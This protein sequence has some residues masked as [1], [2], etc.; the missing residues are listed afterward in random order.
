MHIGIPDH[1]RVRLTLNSRLLHHEIWLPFMRPEELTADRVMVEVDRV[2]HSNDNW[3]FDDVDVN[4]IHAPLPAGAG[5]LRGIGKL[6]SF[7]ERK[8]CIIQIPANDNTCCAR[9]IVTAKARLEEDERW[10]SIRQGRMVQLRLARELLEQA[11]VAEGVACGREEWVKF[12]D[13]LGRDYQI[14]VISRDYFNAVIY[15]GP[16]ASRDGR[17]LYL[18]HARGHFSVITSMP[19]FVE[20]SYYCV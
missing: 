9:A 8:K 2:I 12:Q 3:L 20:R 17:Q 16:E 18:Y 13:V 19:A 6:G 4:F 5:H 7:L 14:V 10:H 1:D 11:G 15:R